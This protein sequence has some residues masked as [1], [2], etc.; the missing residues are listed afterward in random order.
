MIDCQ[1]DMLDDPIAGW[2]LRNYMILTKFPDLLGKPG[3]SDSDRYWSSYYWLAR[4][5]RVWS[6]IA[7]YDAGLEQQ[8]FQMLEHAPDFPERFEEIDAAAERDAMEQL[9]DAGIQ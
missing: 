6:A 4:F 8:V 2:C 1:A 3:L 9:R 5:A 7:G